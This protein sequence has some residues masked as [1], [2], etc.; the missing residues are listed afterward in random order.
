MM[1]K[2]LSDV[3]VH[4]VGKDQLSISSDED[5]LVESFCCCIDLVGS[6]HYTVFVYSK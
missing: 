1:T 4:S 6:W 5:S 2:M 3:E